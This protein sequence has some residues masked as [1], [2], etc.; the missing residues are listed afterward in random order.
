MKTE[1]IWDE[2]LYWDFLRDRASYSKF[3]DIST[4][5]VS[6]NGIVPE[7]LK[8]V[9]ELG[10]PFRLIVG[11]PPKK[12]FHTLKTTN[13]FEKCL[14]SAKILVEYLGP[15][16]RCKVLPRSHLKCV[17]MDGVVVVGGR[18][19]SSSSMLDC[20]VIIRDKKLVTEA[21]DRF[22]LAWAQG[23]NLD[24]ELENAKDY[25][26]G[27]RPTAPS[28]RDYQDPDEYFEWDEPF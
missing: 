19:F 16:M 2:D 11:A 26:K 20:S 18:N 9:K 22:N 14:T 25:T 4:F 17:I 1:L 15:E 27:G 7:F 23:F 12:G 21:R 6:V 8:L 28:Y 24:D 10:I 3:I 5:N 13:S